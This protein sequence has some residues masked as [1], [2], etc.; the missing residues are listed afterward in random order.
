MSDVLAFLVYS[1][2]YKMKTKKNTRKYKKQKRTNKYKIKMPKNDVP[3]VQRS[4]MYVLTTELALSVGVG[5][6]FILS[7]L[8]KPMKSMSMT[9]AV[10]K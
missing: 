3:S 6:C 8:E 10:D 1:L 7:N 2:L 9:R 5:A 4:I